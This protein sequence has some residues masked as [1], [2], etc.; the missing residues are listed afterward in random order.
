MQLR[1]IERGR[2]S[3]MSYIY[4]DVD[5][6]I[7]QPFVGSGTCVDIIK[8]FVPGLQGKPTTS[9][10]K[11]DNVMET[12][13]RIPKGTAIAT[14]ENWRYPGRDHG[15]HAAILVKV[16]AS[17]IWV[18]DQWAGDSKRPNM[19]LCLIR[20]P[21][22]HEQRNPNGTFKRPSDNALAISVIER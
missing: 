10:R 12:G 14:F 20:V 15:N 19:E 6:L 1:R 17:G 5:K 8:L 21:P 3:G 7:N 2:E 11:G 13:S 16:M 4:K 9:W 18:V 22:P